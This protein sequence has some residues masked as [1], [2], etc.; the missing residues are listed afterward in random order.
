MQDR[1]LTTD[2]MSKK[3]DLATPSA[4]SATAFRK[5]LPT[6]SP[7]VTILR[8]HGIEQLF[9][10]TS[11]ILLLWWLREALNNGFKS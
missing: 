1:V 8:L 5:Q 9:S 6:C 4:H 2:N 3:I 11:P 7:N 10:L